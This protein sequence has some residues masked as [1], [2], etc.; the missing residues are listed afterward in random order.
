[1][2]NMFV[3][4][5][6]TEISNKNFSSKV[7]MVLKEFFWIKGGIVWKLLLYVYIWTNFSSIFNSMFK[8]LMF[9]FM[10]VRKDSEFYYYPDL[11]ADF[12]D[13]FFS[14]FDEFGIWHICYEIFALLLVVFFAFILDRFSTEDMGIKISIKG[15]F[16]FITGIFVAFTLVSSINLILYLN[17][18]LKVEGLMSEVNPSLKNISYLIIFQGVLYVLVA[19]QEEMLARGYMINNFKWLQEKGTKGSVMTILLCSGIFAIFHIYN[20]DKIE[21]SNL[22]GLFN[23]GLLAILFCTYFVC[24][25]DLWLLIGAHFGWNFFMGPFYGT[26]V[27]NVEKLQG[28]SV[29][30]VTI[31]G[32][33]YMTGGG[34]GPEG[35]LVTTAILIAIITGVIVI[36]RRKTNLIIKN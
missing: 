20:I 26:T 6:R 27:S 8:W 3:D 29:F 10:V 31:T 36:A 19:I 2:D 4:V 35:S 21:F 17:G 34:F 12:T 9:T 22:L 28:K 13:I 14:S 30:K 23:I 18:N 5:D 25:K 1:M 32:S 7:L 24:Y 11:G 33:E 15:V 16:L